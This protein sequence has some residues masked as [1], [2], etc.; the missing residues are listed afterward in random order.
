MQPSGDQTLPDPLFVAK[1]PVNQVSLKVSG[2]KEHV[3]TKIG[4]ISS[5]ASVSERG[6]RVHK[7]PAELQSLT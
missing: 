4:N 1:I 2:L 7:S 3:Q 6:K 5:T